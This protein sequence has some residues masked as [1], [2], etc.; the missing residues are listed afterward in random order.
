MPLKRVRHVK[1]KTSSSF[2]KLQGLVFM[3]LPLSLPIYLL[4]F[5]KSTAVLLVLLCLLWGGGPDQ[6]KIAWIRWET[7]TS[8]KENGES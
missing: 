3:L 5:Y 8:S 6:N 4:S 7:V 2:F 1:Y